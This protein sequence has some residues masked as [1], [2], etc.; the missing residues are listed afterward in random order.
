MISLLLISAGVAGIAY[1]SDGL[2]VVYECKGGA[3]EDGTCPPEMVSVEVLRRDL[4]TPLSKAE[5]KQLTPVARRLCQSE[6]AFSR[7][8]HDGRKII[9]I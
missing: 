9:T 1:A 3:A 7:V 8:E 5:I 6:A 4:P 2:A